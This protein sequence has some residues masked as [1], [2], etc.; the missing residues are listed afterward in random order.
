M[1]V[2]L[3]G[4]DEKGAP[5]LAH[6]QTV[7]RNIFF[8]IYIYTNTYMGTSP[9]SALDLEPSTSLPNREIGVP[10]SSSSGG[11]QGLNGHWATSF[12]AP[13]GKRCSRYGGLTL[14]PKHLST[15][16]STLCRNRL[17]ITLANL[18]TQNRAFLSINSAPARVSAFARHAFSSAPVRAGCEAIAKGQL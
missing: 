16:E 15:I 2:I 4:S 7:H 13:R 3:S 17:Y 12:H 10:D 18:A 11:C 14:M 5:Q 6:W 8:G 9:E 1:S